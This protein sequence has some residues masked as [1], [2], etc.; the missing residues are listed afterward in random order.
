MWDETREDGNPWGLK[1]KTLFHMSNDS[2]L[3]ETQPREGTLP[4]YE[5]KLI[6]QFDHRWATYEADGSTRD[7]TNA[8]KQN[9]EFEIRPRYWVAKGEVDQRLAEFSLRQDSSSYNPV[10]LVQYLMGWR[11]ITNA[12]N[13]RTDICTVFPLTG[14]GNKIPLIITKRGCKLEACL[15]ADMNSFAH[16]WCARQK[17]GGTSLNFFY[18]KQ[19]PNLAPTAY[20]QADIVFIVPRV[21]ELTYTSHSLK[22]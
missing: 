15:L 8:E 12:T 13:Q 14:V 17:I 18:K 20:T 11:D 19:F 2:N 1:F 22:N 7:V 6:H 4:L 16:D 21:L 10:D 5:A 9:A 3:F